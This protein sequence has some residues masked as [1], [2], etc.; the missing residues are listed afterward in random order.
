VSITLYLPVVLNDR[1]T[2]RALSTGTTRMDL[3]RQAVAEY[4]DR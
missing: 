2:D 4:L 3:I 1:I